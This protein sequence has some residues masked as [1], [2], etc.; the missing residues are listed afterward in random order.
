[1][2]RAT[3]L[4]IIVSVMDTQEATIADMIAGHK[5]SLVTFNKDVDDDELIAEGEGAESPSLPLNFSGG[6]FTTI[7]RV[8]FLEGI[9][10]GTTSVPGLYPFVGREIVATVFPAFSAALTLSIQA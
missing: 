5:A 7:T 3:T 9:I 2:S 8:L 10:T 1:M 4:S 6:G